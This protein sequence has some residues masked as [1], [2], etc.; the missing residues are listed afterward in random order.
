MI[1]L[2]NS[3]TTPLSPAVR[4]AMLDA[5]DCFGNPSSLH[6]AGLAAQKR[7]QSAREA[8]TAALGIRSKTAYRLLFTSS[9]S[10]ANNQILFG[11]LSAKKFRQP[12]RIVTTD[13]EHPSLLA[14]LAVLEKQGVE[15]IRLSTRGGALSLEE[16]EE[17]LT[18][19]TLLLSLMTVN[20]ETGALYDIQSAF[21]LAKAK[22]PAII[23]H[24]D[25][26]Q[27]F[28][29]VRFSPEKAGA[30]AVTISAHKI[31]GPKGVG[32][33]LVAQPLLTSKRLAPLLYGGGQEGGLRSGTENT[34]G[35]AGFGK[36]AEEGAAALPAFL[37]RMPLLRKIFIAALPAE[38]RV[39][40]PKNGAPHILSITLPGIRSETMLHFLSAAG[41]FVSSGSACSSNKKEANYVLPA[42]GL[43]SAE[44]DSTLRISL[45][46]NTTE[47]ELLFTAEK[48]REGLSLLVRR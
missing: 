33:L 26:V 14:P 17:A 34:I 18:D 41:I 38:V 12:P 32:G 22:N 16:L 10:E 11:C 40:T 48:I 31:H 45:S 20:N 47:E 5:M 7:I 6:S 13:S 29:K 9:G 4:A 25:C 21:A 15:V 36:A 30:D 3:A 37:E 23:T 19:N 35:I 44:A 2:D 8:V 24:T 28:L 42:F 46:N 39:N 27:G 43:S 1:Y